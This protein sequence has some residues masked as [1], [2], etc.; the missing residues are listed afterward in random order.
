MVN[1]HDKVHF[2]MAHCAKKCDKLPGAVY[3]VPP[4]GY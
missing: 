4:N 2:M 3:A 1:K